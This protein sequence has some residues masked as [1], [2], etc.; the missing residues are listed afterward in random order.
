MRVRSQRG[1]AVIVGLAIGLVVSALVVSIMSRQ[2]YRDIA[3]VSQ[4]LGLTPSG[5]T[6]EIT[7]ASRIVQT[8]RAKRDHLTAVQLFMSNYGHPNASPVVLTISSSRTNKILRVSSAAPRAV[9]DNR[10]HRFDFLPIPDSANQVLLITVTSPDGTPGRTVTAWL[11]DDDPYPQ[12]TVIVNGT[13]RSRQDLVL[14][15]VYRIGGSVVELVNRASQYKP[16]FFK[17]RNLK[18]L[19]ILALV[20]TVVASG[21]VVDSVLEVNDSKTRPRRRSLPKRGSR[22]RS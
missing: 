19:A 21:A 17:G 1:L 6:G 10:Y 5:L 11:G 15:L 14:T 18:I 8:F 9:Q 3:F 4:P 7:S 20:A 2:E 13:R 16:P 12:G 22:H